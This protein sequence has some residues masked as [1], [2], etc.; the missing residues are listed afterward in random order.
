MP[1]LLCPRLQCAKAAWSDAEPARG[2]ARAFKG[3]VD[4]GLAGH[5]CC[6][7]RRTCSNG[8]VLCESRWFRVD[9]PRDQ[10]S[11]LSALRTVAAVQDSWQMKERG[12]LGRCLWPSPLM[13]ETIA[14]WFVSA[15]ECPY[16]E[17]VMG[18]AATGLIGRLL[19]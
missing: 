1:L 7:G 5:I 17:Y 16:R 12:Q 6:I 9:F 3:V 4:D 13:C 18:G 11:R 14:P 15:R 19:I 8:Y 2:S 10:S